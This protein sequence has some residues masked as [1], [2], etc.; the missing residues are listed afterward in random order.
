VSRPQPARTLLVL[1]LPALS[2]SLAQTM[3]VPAFADLVEE[4]HSDVATVTWL[5][6]GYLVAAAVATP[7]VGRLGD[8]FGKRRMLVLSLVAFTVGNAVSALGTEVGVVIAGRVL[9]GVAGGLF[10]LTFGIIR[11][12]FPREKVAGGVGLISATIGIG[13]GVGLLVG[14]ALVDAFGY[15][16]IFWLSAALSAMSLVAIA[17]FVPESPVRTHGK[18]D[19]RGALALAVGLVLVLVAVSQGRT[20]GWGSASTIG[21]GIG[22]V[23][24]LVLWLLLQRRTAE[25]LVDVAMLARPA[26]LITNTATLLIGFGMFGAYVLVPQLVEAPVSTGYGFGASATHAGLL[27][28][29]GSVGMLVFGPVSGSLGARVGHRVSLGVGGVLASLGLAMLAAFHGSNL[30]IAAWYFV[31]SAGIGFAFAAMPNLILVSVP[32][33]QTGQA[34]GFNAVVRSVGSSVGTQVTA[35]VVVSSTSAGSLVPEES[36]YTAAFVLCAAVTAVAAVVAF[37]IPAGADQRHVRVGDELGA[38]SPLPQ[39][40]F[41]SD[42]A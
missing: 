28:L 6:T 9:Q 39:P 21:A 38:A 10:P 4:L 24:V 23:V 17:L 32:P 22:G 20:W 16:S 42:Q 11:D 12:E 8:M 18:I 31:V 27:L 33:D 40:A 3:L 14:G 26:V 2:F 34:T 25:P 7:L 35:V 36:G 37:L 29:P 19:L 13:G 5:L 15:P 41:S 30:A 1:A